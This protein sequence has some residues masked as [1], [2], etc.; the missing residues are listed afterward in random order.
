MH[1]VGIGME[2]DPELVIDMERQQ[3]IDG[4]NAEGGIAVL[5]H[6]GWSLNT[7]KDSQDLHG[8]LATEIYNA[9]SEAN[10]SIRPYSDHYV[11]VCA[12]AGI[13]YKI[14]AT[15]DTHY[16]DGSDECKGW[17]TVRAEELTRE[18]ILQALRNG[19]FYASQ[20]PDLH[21][22]REENT[23][24]IDTSPCSYISVVS[25]LAWAQR[26]LRGDGI[27]HGAVL[28]DEALQIMK[29]RGVYYVS[30]ASGITA[31]AEKERKNGSPCGEPHAPR[32]RSL[33]GSREGMICT[34][35][36]SADQPPF[37]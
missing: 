20:G 16:Y 13:Y 12:N 5:V 8:F 31:V 15:D 9:V 29:D 10:Q 11:D 18:A 22:R 6:P 30:T 21:V 1:I 34:V 25:N 36:G 4:V 28:T 24:I 19:D 7:L 14:F 33:K 35:R 27:E 3:I 32:Q 17:V 26:T 23:L 2:C 37:R